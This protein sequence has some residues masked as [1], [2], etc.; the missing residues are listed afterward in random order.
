VYDHVCFVLLMD[1]VACCDV[2]DETYLLLNCC[3]SLPLNF[4]ISCVNLFSHFIFVYSDLLYS[5]LL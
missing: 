5:T 2:A 3:I 1:A 4:K